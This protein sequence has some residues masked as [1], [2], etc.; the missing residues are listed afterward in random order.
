M[1]V[2]GGKPVT[3]QLLAEL[4]QVA[5]ELHH[6]LVRHCPP[7]G[8]KLDEHSFEQALEQLEEGGVLAGDPVAGRDAVV[9]EQLHRQHGE[10]DAG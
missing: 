9:L 8:V 5:V 1:L 4:Q 3:A 7:E 2:E 6:R 10:E